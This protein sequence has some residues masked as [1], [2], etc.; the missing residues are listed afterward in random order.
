MARNKKGQFTRRKRRT[1]KARKARK[2]PRV[3]AARKPAARRHKRRRGRING[4][5]MNKKGG[6]IMKIAGDAALA[7]GGAIG[8]RILGK[9]AS[10]KLNTS[11]LVTGIGVFALGVAV[12]K[13]TGNKALGLGIAASGGELAASQVLPASIM[14]IGDID[15]ADV[16]AIERAAMRGVEDVVNGDGDDDVLNGED[17][18]VTGDDDD[19][20]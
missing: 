2:A 8:G 12:A 7:T 9:M 14:G 16:D 11:P 13:M 10:N 4:A 20:A 15:A 5:P 19:D 6:S 17:D 3:A 1:T 18:V